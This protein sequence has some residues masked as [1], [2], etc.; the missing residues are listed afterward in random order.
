MTDVASPLEDHYGASCLMEM[1]P[2]TDYD[3]AQYAGKDARYS[4]MTADVRPDNST[5]HLS[6]HER[7]LYARWHGQLSCEGWNL[8]PVTDFHLMIPVRA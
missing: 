6:L 3:H 4:G 8:F 1:R 7:K 5:Y 2:V